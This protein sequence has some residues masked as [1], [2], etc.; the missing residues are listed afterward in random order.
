MDLE[1]C[2]R[3]GGVLFKVTNFAG[4]HHTTA[5]ELQAQCGTNFLMKPTAE[6]I[7]LSGMGKFD[8]DFRG[9]HNIRCVVQALE[10]EAI[11]TLMF[12]EHTVTFMLHLSQLPPDASGATY[13]QTCLAL[14]IGAQQH[15]TCDRGT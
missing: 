15:Y 10:A 5:L 4:C 8:S 13:P 7:D 2:Y 12:H 1:V 9:C 6:G 3:D 11:S 14:L